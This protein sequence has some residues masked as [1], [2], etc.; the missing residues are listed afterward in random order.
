MRTW[1]LALKLALAPEQ[2]RK[3]ELSVPDLVLEGHTD[4]A[5]FALGCSIAEP[6]VASGGQD[7]NV[8]PVIFLP[9]SPT[10]CSPYTIH[11][12]EYF[13]GTML[14]WCLLGMFYKIGLKA[15]SGQACAQS[16]SDQI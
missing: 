11:T 7:K 9:A 8:R 1:L 10:T 5:Q 15:A 3:N 16:Q 6:Y 2:G 12:C 14:S 4:N 13:M